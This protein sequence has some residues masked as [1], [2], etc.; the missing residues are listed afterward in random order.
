M[1]GT[2][3]GLLLLL[4][5]ALVDGFPLAAPM[6]FLADITPQGVATFISTVRSLFGSGTDF[7]HRFGYKYENVYNDQLLTSTIN[8]YANEMQRQEEIKQGALMVKD[9][10]KE[11][12]F[13]TIICVNL[14]ILTAGLVM[15]LFLKI[16]DEYREKV[17]RKQKDAIE[18]YN[19]DME[20]RTIATRG[21]V[22]GG[23]GV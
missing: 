10:E 9:M 15:I 12:L 6:D 16:R 14:G 19:R 11:Q 22:R 4:S 21:Q 2:R 8:A 17:D 7:T 5:L 18:N 1:A 3:Y 20:L 13:F 23:E